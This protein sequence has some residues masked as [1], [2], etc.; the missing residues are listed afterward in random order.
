MDEN[1]TALRIADPG[2]RALF[3]LES[4]W[5]AWLDVEAALA[6]AEAELGMIPAAAAVEI[7]AKARLGLLDRE[8]IEE[9]LRRTAHQL[10][11]LVWELTRVCEGDAG[12]Y[13]HW[14][15]TTQNVVQ[16]GDLLVLRR[17]HGIFLGQIGAA[18]AAMADLAERSA[19]MALPGRTHGQHAVPITFGLKVAVWIDEFCRHVERLRAVEPRIFVCL[20][21]GAAGSAASFGEQGLAVQAALARRLGMG[22]MAVPARTIGDH[23]AEYVCLLAL[24]A[25]SAAKV[26]QEIYTGMKDEFGEVEEPVPAGTVGSSTMPQKRNPFLSQDV[27]AAAA[28]VRSR[29]GLALEAMATEHE[30]DRRTSLMMR[31]ALSE[32]C[33]LTGDILARLEVLVAGL[34]LNPE[35]MRGNLELTG[36]LI[37][38]EAIMLALGAHV[39]RQEAHDVVYDAAQAAATGETDF[40]SLLGADARVRQHLS[41]PEIEALIDPAAYTGRSAWIAT[42]QAR[43]ARELA[44]ELSAPGP[45]L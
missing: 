34:N 43:R 8:R 32:S 23:E 19:E 5:Q 25:Q 21:G 20:L 45:S 42:E 6:E 9:G 11:P 40:A 17:A 24:V 22:A 1:P 15:A 13:V 28:E 16:T 2:I 10:V 39:G 33:A 37:M 26:A 3:H 7:R 18:L 41:A 14:G 29:V 38:A 36:G 44:A 31:R 12:D 4:R 27:M 30:A 35:R